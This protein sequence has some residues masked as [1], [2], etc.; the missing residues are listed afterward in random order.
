MGHG[1]GS[2]PS[3][4]GPGVADQAAPDDDGAGQRQPELHYE[5]AAFGALPHPALLVGPGM[6]THDRPSVV[7]HQ[8]IVRPVLVVLYVISFRCWEEAPPGPP[9][10]GRPISLTGPSSRII[11]M[12][13]PP[14]PP[15]TTLGGL[16][17]VQGRCCRQRPPHPAECRA[18]ITAGGTESARPPINDPEMIMP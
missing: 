15:T 1:V 2:Y 16:A 3:Y 5:P 8:G 17:A 11:G 6:D 13:P 14:P 9:E 10:P 12:T 4:S 7:P 18:A